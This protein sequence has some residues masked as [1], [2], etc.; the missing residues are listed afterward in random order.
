MIDSTLIAKVTPSRKE[1]GHL[2]S[3]DSQEVD[4]YFAEKNQRVW[5]GGSDLNLEG[6]WTWSDC[7]RWN[8]TNWDKANLAGD[9]FWPDQP[10]NHTVADYQLTNANTNR[11]LT[12]QY[13]QKHPDNYQGHHC[14]FLRPERGW[15][16]GLCW[17]KE[18]FVCASSDRS[19][20]GDFLKHL[21]QLAYFRGSVNNACGHSG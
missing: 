9:N 5:I 7:S 20:E 12:Y 4:D 18:R 17:V 10:D 13:W 1:G 16:D 15:H 14:T 8:W 19:C 21:N 11:M 3:I 6:T 2:A